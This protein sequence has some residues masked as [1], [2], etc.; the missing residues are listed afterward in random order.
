[1]GSKLVATTVRRIKPFEWMLGALGA[2]LAIAAISETTIVFAEADY[3]VKKGDTLWDIAAEKLGEARE[4]PQLWEDNKQIKDPHWI[5][6][7]DRIRLAGEGVPGEAMPV[8]H[9]TD[10]APAPEK[11]IYARNHASG[12]VGSGEFADAGEIIFSYRDTEYM[13]EGVEAFIN[14]GVDDGV[15]VGDWFLIFRPGEKVSHPHTHEPAG[16]RVVERGHLKVLQVGKDSSRGMIK[17]SF[18]FIQRGDRVIPFKPFPKSITIKAAPEGLAGTIIAEQEGRLDAGR[19]DLVHLDVGSRNGIEVGSRLAVFKEGATVLHPGK[20][21]YELPPDV[22]GEAVVVR[23][24]EDTST[25]LLTRASGPVRIGNRVAALSGLLQPPALS[26]PISTD[27]AVQP[28]KEMDKGPL[29]V[30]PTKQKER[31]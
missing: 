7:G 26:A 30:V 4:W 31:L 1:M 9:P 23:A 12:F 27:P 8:S 28:V 3:T 5:Y 15:R 6:P 2:I 24:Q 20:E 13:Y 16:V 11:L 17:R 18:S 22:I 14:L 25:A 10:Y 29:F 19:E 21:D